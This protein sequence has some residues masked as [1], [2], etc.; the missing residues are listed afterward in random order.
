MNCHEARKHWHLYHD[1]EGDRELYFQVNEHL[2]DCADCAEWFHEQS[3][4]EE[5]ISAKLGADHPTADV[6]NSVLV[7]SGLQKAPSVRRWILFGGLLAMAAGLL[8]ALGLWQHF[9]T[10]GS[11]DLAK[12]TAACH[13]ELVDGRKDVEFQ[14]QSDMEVEAY[15]RKRVNFPVRCPPREDAGFLVEG[16]GIC[17]MADRQAAYLVGHVDGKAVS[18]FII[19]RESLA[20]FP[21]QLD[22]LRRQQTHV[23]REAGY[24]MVMAQIDK[25]VVLVI[26][27]ANGGHLLRVLNAYGTYPH[28]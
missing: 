9:G 13:N 7:Q 21:R 16:A 10:S 11:P 12:L 20:R 18:I 5:L 23:C 22:A 1:S 15:L 28:G 14:S 2:S 19:P 6:W 8:V 4:L 24:E 26:G 25:N 17:H 27:R 3:W